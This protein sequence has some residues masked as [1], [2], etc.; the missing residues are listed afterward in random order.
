MW[1]MIHEYIGQIL[2]YFDKNGKFEDWKYVK[3]FFAHTTRIV[4]YE[5]NIILKE[6]I[7]KIY[8]RFFLFCYSFDRD[9]EE[10]ILKNFYEVEILSGTTNYF[11]RK[12][13]RIME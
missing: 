10:E 4:G 5:N 9:S 13:T 6:T 1:Q 12:G 7:C 2:K 11:V 3:K 8:D